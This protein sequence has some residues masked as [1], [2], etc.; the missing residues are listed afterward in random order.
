MERS[1]EV[2]DKYKLP[3]LKFWIITMY[4]SNLEV[5]FILNHYVISVERY[6]LGKVDDLQYRD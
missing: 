2:N 1:V 6:Y 5:Q 3:Y 4:I